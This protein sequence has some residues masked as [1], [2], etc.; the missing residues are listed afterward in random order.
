MRRHELDPVS[1]TF[2]FAF[3]V[4]G[5]LFLIGQADQ[6]LRLHWVWPLLLLVLGAGI[7]LDV[8]RTRS[9]PDDTL[10]PEAEA[11]PP[12]PEPEAAPLAPEPE[13]VTAELDPDPAAREAVDNR[14]RPS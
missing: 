6:A 12:A 3:T 5:L 10:A 1:L 7:L 4:L 9:R 11:A 14:E 2:G 13:P 8:T